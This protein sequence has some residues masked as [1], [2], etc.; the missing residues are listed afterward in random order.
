MLKWKRRADPQAAP[1]SQGHQA[2][3]SSK[4]KLSRTGPPVIRTWPSS[5]N[6]SRR[7]GPERLVETATW[8]PPPPCLWPA[9]IPAVGWSRCSDCPAVAH[10]ALLQL[11]RAA[12]R[13]GRLR[14]WQRC[15]VPLRA[16]I[17]GP[18]VRFPTACCA[19]AGW[20]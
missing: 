19:L 9:S 18:L 14:L 1:R 2:R 16:P 13:V 8:P 4:T 3:P 17:R 10:L 15:C 6:L 7:H 11:H 12:L 20:G 5:R